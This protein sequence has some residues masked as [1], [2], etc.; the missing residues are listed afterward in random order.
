MSGSQALIVDTI[1][2]HC[3]P[4]RVG[5]VQTRGLH[6]PVTQYEKEVIGNGNTR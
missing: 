5:E 3:Y 6:F 1:S 2:S 4:K